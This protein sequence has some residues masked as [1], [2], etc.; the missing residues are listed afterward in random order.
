M[1]ILLSYRHR[2]ALDHRGI[3]SRHREGMQA[4]EVKQADVRKGRFAYAY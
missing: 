4:Q 2:K 3:R 1:G